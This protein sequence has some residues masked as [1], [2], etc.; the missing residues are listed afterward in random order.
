MKKKWEERRKREERHR[1]E[2]DTDL[3]PGREVRQEENKPQGLNP[4]FWPL[5]NTSRNMGGLWSLQMAYCS[6]HTPT[7]VHKHTY[8]NIH[9]HTQTYTHTHTQTHTHTLTQTHTHIHNS[10]T[11]T[12]TSEKRGPLHLLSFMDLRDQKIGN[13]YNHV[14]DPDWTLHKTAPETPSA[15]KKKKQKEKKTTSQ[16][17]HLHTL[18]REQAAHRQE[19]TAW[20]ISIH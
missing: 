10:S 8:A 16:T 19:H 18:I 11:H 12:H 9:T 13:I 1:R 5:L 4:M 7:H 15:L 2:T 14:T 6:T 3:T 20:K 17:I